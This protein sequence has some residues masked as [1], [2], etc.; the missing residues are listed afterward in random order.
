MQQR[1]VECRAV[2]LCNVIEDVGTSSTKP[3]NVKELGPGGE[4]WRS[5]RV[6]RSEG[7]CEELRLIFVPLEWRQQQRASQSLRERKCSRKRSQLNAKINVAILEVGEREGGSVASNIRPK[8]IR[9][10]AA[11][12]PGSH[13]VIKSRGFISDAVGRSNPSLHAAATTGFKRKT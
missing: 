12:T 13:G 10:I 7:V 11:R 9:A 4:M 3:I 5:A 1:A 2:V 8:N 6:R